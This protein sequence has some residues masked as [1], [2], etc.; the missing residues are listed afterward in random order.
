MRFKN[1]KPG[2]KRYGNGS[3]HKRLGG[4]RV[5]LARASDYWYELKEHLEVWPL[6]SW[7]RTWRRLE[8]ARTHLWRIEIK[9]D[10]YFARKYGH[11]PTLY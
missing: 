3:F 11:K 7:K 4:R 2:R 8:Q 1:K 9:L 5:Q 10:H 6:R